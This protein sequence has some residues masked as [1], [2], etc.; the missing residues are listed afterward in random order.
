MYCPHNAQIRRICYESEQTLRSILLQYS[1]AAIY[2][3]DK[4]EARELSWLMRQKFNERKWK[5][6]NVGNLNK[7]FAYSLNGCWL[8]CLES[9]KDLGIR[10][11]KKLKFNYQCLEARIK[12]NRML[13]DIKRNASYESKFVIRFLYNGYIRLHIEYYMQ[14]W[15]PYFIQNIDMLEAVQRWLTKLITSLRNKLDECRLREL[16]K[17]SARY[18]FLRGHMIEVYKNMNGVKKNWTSTVFLQWESRMELRVTAL[19][20]WNRI[21]RSILS[22]KE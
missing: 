16:D 11:D 12:A 6:L 19:L 7:N 20:L 17:F 5:V 13:E 15:Q 3:L 9:K 1:H 10:I 8:E 22:R 18:R 21:I 4:L 2:L 14:A